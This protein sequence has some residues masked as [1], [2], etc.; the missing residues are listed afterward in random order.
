MFDTYMVQKTGRLS[1]GRL[2]LRANAQTNPGADAHFRH[3]QVGKLADPLGI[4]VDPGERTQ[5]V[6]WAN[7]LCLPAADEAN[8]RQG[9]GVPGEA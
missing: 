7:D 5:E 1:G 2:L 9:S 6:E 8:R 4:V 3:G